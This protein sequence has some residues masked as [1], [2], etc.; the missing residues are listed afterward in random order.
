MI[1]NL[2]KTLI[3]LILLVDT[4]WAAK[5]KEKEQSKKP[6]LKLK[7]IWKQRFDSVEA[8]ENSILSKPDEITSEMTPRIIETEDK[9]IFFDDEGKIK[10]E[11][12]IERERFEQIRFSKRRSYV[13]VRKT[14]GKISEMEIPTPTK[15]QVYDKNGELKYEL[16]GETGKS[17]IVSEKGQCLEVHHLENAFTLFNSNGEE[18]TLISPLDN[19]G[20]GLGSNRFFC[21][22]S[23]NGERI[24]LY[25]TNFTSGTNV[26]DTEVF[27][28]V[29]DNKGNELMRKKVENVLYSTDVFNIS[30]DGEYI[31][32]AT[33]K[34]KEMHPEYGPLF[35]RDG[36]LLDKD[37]GSLIEPFSFIAGGDC[38]IK[39]DDRTKT[40]IS[41]GGVN[42]I[43]IV[44]TTGKE[45]I[46]DSP[47]S[48]VEDNAISSKYIA[49]VGGKK[50]G[51]VVIL[52]IYDKEGN[53]L[54]NRS[55]GGNK[56]DLKMLRV[57]LFEND[58][59]AVKFSNEIRYYKISEI[60]K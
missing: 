39:Y 44:D 10:K 49:S 48:N 8:N 51:N 18:I 3:I 11:L 37:G 6:E 2:L 52:K 24:L 47:D 53:L 55:L 36:I 33:L 13:M 5:D 15:A 1:K 20:M 58:I 45:T 50:E 38:T 22:F 27:V 60:G 35:Q 32:I 26:Y 41:I 40:F 46:I 4:A 19:I 12:V 34:I 7:L 29:F 42:E 59:V 9:L 57:E 43:L 28:I 23:G 25:A 30:E 14:I 21:K 16:D 56:K 31:F 54:L 17:Y